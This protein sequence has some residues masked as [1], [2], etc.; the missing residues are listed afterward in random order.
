M[1][2]RYD[3]FSGI[4]E[5]KEKQE[6]KTRTYD[7]LKEKHF[8]GLQSRLSLKERQFVVCSMFG[9]FFFILNPCGFVVLQ[10]VY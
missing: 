2:S 5:R 6:K 7:T 9:F 8:L 3:F 10:V 1:G 4:I